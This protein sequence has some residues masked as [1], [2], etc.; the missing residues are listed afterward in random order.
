MLTTPSVRLATTSDLPGMADAL[1]ESFHDD[2]A[3]PPDEGA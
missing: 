1:A 3:M 2:P